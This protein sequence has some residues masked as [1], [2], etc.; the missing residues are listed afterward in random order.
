M[1]KLIDSEKLKAHYA[2]W[3]N[4][5]KDTFDTIVDLQPEVEAIPVEWIIGHECMPKE[6]KGYD[7]IMD[8]IKTWREENAETD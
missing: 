3:D 7:A 8:M 1:P 2:W 6:G 5:N 4:E